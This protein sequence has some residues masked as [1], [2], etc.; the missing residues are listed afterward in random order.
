MVNV[1]QL[2]DRWEDR[3]DIK[4]L[5]GKYVHYLLLKKEGQIVAD[6]WANRD[7]IC[8]GVNEGWYNGAEAVGGYFGFIHGRTAKVASL[9]RAKFP[10]KL[11]DKTDEEIFGI[12]LMEIKSIS[13]YIIEVADDGQTAKAYC[14]VFGYNTTCDEHGPVSNWVLATILMDLVLEDEEWKIWHM[15]YLEDIAKPA[16]SDWTDPAYPYPELPEFAELKGLVPPQP[17]VATVL[18]PRYTPDRPFTKLPPTP[19]PYATFAETFSY[20]M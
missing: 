11:Q 7:D 9:L 6:L 12:G 18:R 10:E 13:N 2:V 17:N 3:R 4:N 1:E 20:G 5:M 14:C 19:Q 16:G 8:Y 15:Q